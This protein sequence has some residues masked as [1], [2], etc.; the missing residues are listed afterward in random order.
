MY[1][2]KDNSFFLMQ[3]SFN[4]L[5]SH[6]IVFREFLSNQNLQLIVSCSFRE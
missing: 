3:G 5:F 2:H 6:M 4:H 1:E